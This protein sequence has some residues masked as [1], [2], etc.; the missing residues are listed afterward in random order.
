MDKY[1]GV[2][3]VYYRHTRDKDKIMRGSLEIKYDEPET[4]EDKLVLKG[5]KG[6]YYLYEPKS[7]NSQNIIRWVCEIYEE[8]EA[9]FARLKGNGHEYKGIVR[10]IGRHYLYFNYYNLGKYAEEMT[11]IFDFRLEENFEILT[12]SS[13]A[14]NTDGNPHSSKAILYKT[15]FQIFEEVGDHIIE[16]SEISNHV[17]DYVEYTILQALTEVEKNNLIATPVFTIEKLNSTLSQEIITSQSNFYREVL[18]SMSQESQNQL[19][20]FIGV[21]HAYFQHTKGEAKIR[22]GD[23]EVWD[24]AQSNFKVRGVLNNYGYNNKFEGGTF[25]YGN[26]IYICI[27]NTENEELDLLVSEIS[28]KVPY[29]ILSFMYVGTN[30]ENKPCSGKEI[31]IKTNLKNINEVKTEVNYIEYNKK[32]QSDEEKL[33]IRYFQLQK[34]ALLIADSFG[35]ESFDEFEDWILEEENKT[36]KL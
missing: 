20:G 33:V 12:D 3:L 5:F 32:H 36:S 16:I 11:Q 31:L 19:R 7:D 15:D 26:F 34:N 35:C 13:C 25:I 17:S 30:I 24:N 6:I 14:I 21:Y 8:D 2:Y 18:S 27:K 23:I 22:K 9:F 29:S 28:P 1:L 4:V 10:I